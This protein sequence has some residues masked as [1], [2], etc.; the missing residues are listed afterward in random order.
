MVDVRNP[1]ADWLPRSHRVDL[2]CT[3]C[4]V[5]RVRHDDNELGH[6]WR[7]GDLDPSTL[8][9]LPR[10][11]ARER[12]GAYAIPLPRPEERRRIRLAAGFTQQDLAEAI[13]TS[14]TAVA[15]FERTA[16][17]IDG[18]RLPGREPSGDTRRRYAEMLGL[19]I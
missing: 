14:R 2:P 10:I 5:G 8:A 9:S 17:Y 15:R 18:L 1:Q 6:P 4:G 11:R 16:G 19:L 13:G 3:R 12:R 7:N